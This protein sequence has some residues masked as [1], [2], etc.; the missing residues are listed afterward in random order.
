MTNLIPQDKLEKATGVICKQGMFPFPLSET[1]I[2]IIKHVVEEERE[3]DLICAFDQ[4]SSQ[5]MEQLRQTSGFSEKTIEKLTDRLAKAGLIFNQ[6]SSKG[7]MI[8]RLLPLV[9][10]GLME[11]RFMTELTGNDE[12]RELAELFE[13]LLAELRDEIQ[14][15]YDAL[16][17]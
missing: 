7:V 12:E 1:A 14:H 6:P 3:L 5:T 2:T 16:I 4:A 10:I 8:Y 9:M 11:Y 13:T 17:D 15:N